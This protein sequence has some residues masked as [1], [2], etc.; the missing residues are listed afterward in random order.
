MKTSVLNIY[1]RIDRLEQFSRA[2]DVEVHCVPE[3][4]KENV[5]ATATVSANTTGCSFAE[6]D[7]THCT[8][9]AKMNSHCSRPRPISVS[10]STPRLS[11]G[12]LAATISFDTK[13]KS[14]KDELDTGHT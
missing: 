10:F 14:S 2:D 12:L 8:R 4:K 7:I 9:I 11:D 1:S 3:R 13:R 6:A 5:I